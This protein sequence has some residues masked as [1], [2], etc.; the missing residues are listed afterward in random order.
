VAEADDEVFALAVAVLAVDGDAQAESN[1]MR[2]M[3]AG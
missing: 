3:T 1:A 2:M